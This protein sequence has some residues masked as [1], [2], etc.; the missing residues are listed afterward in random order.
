MG[1]KLLSAELDT[2]QLLVL[3][4]V[5]VCLVLIIVLIIA[6]I[7]HRAVMWHWNNHSPVRTVAARV[8]T[9]RRA[10]SPRVHSGRYTSSHRTSSRGASY[11]ASFELENGSSMELR[12]NGAYDMLAE[13]DVGALTYQ[14]TQYQG[15]VRRM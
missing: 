5:L 15:F 1:T 6:N 14:G 9:K 12:V 8:V 2:A 11:Y 13:G 10:V 7:V 3:V 4:I